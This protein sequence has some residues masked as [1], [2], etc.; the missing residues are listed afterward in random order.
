VYT[1]T[2][3]VFHFR[4]E[5]SYFDLLLLNVLGILSM[6]AL[7][8]AFA[9]RIRSEELANGLL[10]LITFPMMIFSGVFFSLEGTPAVFQ[11]FSQVF[12]MTHYIQASRAVMLEGAGLVQVAPDVLFLTLFT[13]GCLAI[14]AWLFRWE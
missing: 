11:E 3:L 7:G 2:N 12:P 5:G 1:G 9:S 14:A 13:A 10:N 8:L 4:M 6:V